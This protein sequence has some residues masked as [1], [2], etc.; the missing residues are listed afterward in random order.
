MVALSGPRP[1]A[2]NMVPQV[3]SS[4]VESFPVFVHLWAGSSLYI[5]VQGTPVYNH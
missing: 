1:P 2:A 5:I 4:Q 3:H